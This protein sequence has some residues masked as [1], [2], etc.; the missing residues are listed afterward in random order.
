MGPWDPWAASGRAPLGPLGPWAP[1]AAS[2][3]APR[4]PLGPLGPLGPVGQ[5]MTG[6]LLESFGTGIPPKGVGSSSLWGWVI[7]CPLGPMGPHGAQGA[8]DDPTLF[9]GVPVPKQSGRSHMAPNILPRQD[10]WDPLGAHVA[11]FGGFA[12]RNQILRIFMEE[13]QFRNP[14]F[15]NHMDSVGPMVPTSCPGGMIG[16]LAGCW[17]PARVQHPALGRGPALGPRG[18][19]GP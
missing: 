3:R 14:T 7:I 6:P 19:L 5:M 13:E 1:W 16:A 11:W 8:D 2:G 12:S 9:E 15:G 10:V 17:H 4:G 18:R